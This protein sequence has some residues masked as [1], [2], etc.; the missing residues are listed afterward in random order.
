MEK[1][2]KILHMLVAVLTIVLLA[3]LAWQCIDI[4]LSDDLSFTASPYSYTNVSARLKHFAIPIG[5]YIVLIVISQFVSARASHAK[6][7]SKCVVS[8]HHKAA[9]TKAVPAEGKV[10]NMRLYL[11]I[12]AAGLMFWGTANGSLYDVLVKS[13]NICTECIGLG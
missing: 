12:I 11:L 13:I 3:A 10:R 4:Y 9:Y 2:M 8:H 1:I 7:V 6:S 5:M